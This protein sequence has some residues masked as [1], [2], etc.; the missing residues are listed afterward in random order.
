[1]SQITRLSII[2]LLSTTQFLHCQREML[3]EALYMHLQQASHGHAL[4]CDDEVIGK[5]TSVDCLLRPS[6]RLLLGGS[7][8]QSGSVTLGGANDMLRKGLRHS[9]CK[10]PARASITW[11][12]RQV[13]WK[14]ALL[15][16]DSVTNLIKVGSVVPAIR[17]NLQ[18]NIRDQIT[19]HYNWN[20]IWYRFFVYMK[21]SK[22]VCEH[23]ANANMMVTV[24]A[25]EPGRMNMMLVASHPC[26][27]SSSIILSTS[28]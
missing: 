16:T 21:W 24:T 28:Y 23:D 22:C 13:D 7:Y 18:R 10:T 17:R 14:R 20:G 9:E 12:M 2:K 4:P 8:P 1:M 27:C 25:T 26:T 19:V 15:P 5:H 3:H 6:T 11:P